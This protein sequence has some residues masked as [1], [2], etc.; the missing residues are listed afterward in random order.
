MRFFVIGS[1][2]YAM[3]LASLFGLE[4]NGTVSVFFGGGGWPYRHTSLAVWGR[5]P[6]PFTPTPVP[7]LTTEQSHQRV[8]LGKNRG[9]R[10]T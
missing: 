5:N 8:R 2:L 9:F 6:P 1:R 3:R 7:F 10:K 4:P